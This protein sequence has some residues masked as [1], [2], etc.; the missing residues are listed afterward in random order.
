MS[1][2][3]AFAIYKPNEGKA[4][5]L[6]DMVKK[7]LPKLR[8]YGLITDRDVYLARSSDGSII[9]VFEWAGPD[10]SRRAHEHPAIAAIWEAMGA[11]AEFPVLATLPEAGSRFP[12]FAM[13]RGTK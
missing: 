11:V 13:I 1:N 10:A 4:D 9:E 3:M 12:N 8:E 5:E 6:M 7:H 2:Q